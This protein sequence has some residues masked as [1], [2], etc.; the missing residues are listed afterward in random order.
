MVPDGDGLYLA[1]TRVGVASWVYRYRSGGSERYM[2]LGPLRHVNLSAARQLADKARALRRSGVDPVEQ[3]RAQRTEQAVAAA[4]TVT[5]SKCA[6]EYIVSHRAGWRSSAHAAQW[7]ATLDMYVF[8]LIGDLPIQAIDTG[9]VLRVLEPIWRSKTDTAS[10]LRG[11]IEAVLDWAATHGYR[12]GDN[13]ARWK[14]HLQNVLPKKSAVR[15]VV[16]RA[17]IPYVQIGAFLAELRQRHGV[18]A[19]ALEF[20][21]L[22]G[23]R[24]SEAI[25]ARWG[26]FDMRE[27]IWIIP[28]ERMKAGKEHRVPLSDAAVAVLEI[29]AAIR[30]GDFVFPG[31]RVGQP[32]PRMALIHL[33]GRM[34]RKDL[35]T[36]GFRSAL[37]DWAA[38]RGFPREVREQALA[39]ALGSQVEAAYRRTDLFAAREQLMRQWAAY[40]SAPVSDAVVP[41][42][43]AG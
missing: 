30:S 8:P 23:V 34:G 37:T 6:E 16:H 25:R 18:A 43:A 33:L 7:A 38:D 24:T 26:E 11:R 17:A 4:K 28:A 1:V 41:L 39:H 3:R 27:R 29:M 32:L 5:F 13:P 42:R 15:R 20:V 22:T 10:R 35:T 31:T 14:G 19:R 9:L 12:Q 40:C 21:V 36:H 2:G